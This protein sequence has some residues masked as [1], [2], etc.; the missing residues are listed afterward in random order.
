MSFLHVALFRWQPGVTA[1]HVAEIT[2]S[3]GALAETLAGCESYACG[4]DLGLREN[5]F[6]YGVV[7]AF[8]SKGAWQAY[9][10]HPEHVRVAEQLIAPNV[11][12]RAS[13]Q[14]EG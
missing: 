9:V 10:E 5:S 11:S 2:R 1:E 4:A 3:L 13:V 12:E 14:L 6:D 8:E 7:A